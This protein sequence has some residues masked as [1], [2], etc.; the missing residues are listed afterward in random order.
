MGK[1]VPNSWQVARAAEHKRN[2][3]ANKAKAALEP[4]FAPA[5]KE[6]RSILAH[7]TEDVDEAIEMVL[8]QF[9]DVAGL[10]DRLDEEDL[11]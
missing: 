2:A 7:T 10:Q 1:F 8:A 11:G 9:P 4:T 5:L 6:L 3:V